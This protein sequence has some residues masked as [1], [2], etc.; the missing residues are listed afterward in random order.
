MYKLEVALLGSSAAC[1]VFS[2]C[3]PICLY[4]G[5]M[6]NSH[7]YVYLSSLDI[8]K[9][10]KFTNVMDMKWYLIDILIRIVQS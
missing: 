1:Q 5:V 6:V 3:S 8:V 4:G 7:C 2:N 9:L 10:L